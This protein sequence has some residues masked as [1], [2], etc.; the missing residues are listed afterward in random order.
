MSIRFQ[1]FRS[2]IKRGLGLSLLSLLAACGSSNT[3]LENSNG[4]LLT[5]KLNN[6]DSQQSITQKY[7]GQ[8][9][10]WHPEEGYA[11]LKLSTQA[12]TQL[13]STGVSMQGTTL[14]PNASTAAPEANA[15]GSAS[16]AW[17]GG[18]NTWAGGWNTWAGG[19]NTW[20]GGWSAWAGGTADGGPG[21]NSNAWN[22]IKLREAHAI[23]RKFG[24]GVKVAV[25]DTGI[26][27]SHP[28][29]TGRLAPN[30]EW[31][32]FIQN[33]N[34]P[35][36]DCCG[37]AQGH[38]TAVAGVI[39]QVAPKATILP[40][41]VLDSNGVG[42]VDN[43]IAAIDYAMTA[44]AKIINLSLGTTVDVSGL[45]NILATAKTKG[46][47]V[48]ASAGNTGGSL[49]YPGNYAWFIN[50]AVASV[51]STNAQGVLSGF[52]AYNGYLYTLAPGEAIA[53][54]GYGSRSGQF[55]GTS[56]AAPLVS[57]AAA[58]VLG[59][60]P[61][62]SPL[63]AIYTSRNSAVRATTLTA[64]GIDL[65][66]Y[67]NNNVGM[68]D[69]ENLLR[70]QTGFTE[71]VY[72]IKSVKSSKCLDVPNASLT[73]G[74]K[75]QQYTC[76]GTNAQRW[77]LTPVGEYYSIKNVNSGKALDVSGGSTAD[78]AS[79][80]QYAY[81]GGNNELWKVMANGTGSFELRPV[82]SNKCADV[83]SGSIADGALVDQWTCNG[84]THQKWTIVL[85][86]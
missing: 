63:T 38:G 5:V 17:A 50:P 85:A 24:Q 82:H 61:S 86:N 46:V 54:A 9:I 16:T 18:W 36:D 27:T 59:E 56:F 72:Y 71:P 64:R 33:D 12:L 77:K 28:M 43:V 84:G 74:T 83:A 58:L 19:W 40:I 66:A 81:S 51:G 47:Y 29:F 31:R 67:P 41:R 73:D 10:V 57:G 7:G 14:D 52:S 70:S 45:Y 1:G 42:T 11:I 65:W 60:F 20:A 21:L 6:S 25:I 69:L 23:S 2:W 35:T 15:L 48:V 53:S 44:G 37:T 76:N 26:D 55:T 78:G 80:I 75:M 68:L 13:K 22:Q 39:L 3:S 49:T 8:A 62:V 79:I 4:Y 30:S 32:D 34:N